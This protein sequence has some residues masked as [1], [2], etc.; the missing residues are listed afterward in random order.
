MP[1][2]TLVVWVVL[3]S[4]ALAAHSARTNP[5]ITIAETIVKTVARFKKKPTSISRRLSAA[6]VSATGAASKTR[7]LTRPT[8]GAV[9]TKPT[10]KKKKMRQVVRAS[11]SLAVAQP[12]RM[13][14]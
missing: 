3:V 2:K 9:A 10:T 7:M 12:R 8:N 11:I 5:P 14:R 13:R 6:Y 1:M 4:Q